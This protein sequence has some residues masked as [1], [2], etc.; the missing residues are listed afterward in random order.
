MPHPC[1]A[2]DDAMAKYKKADETL[3]RYQQHLQEAALAL[4]N[5]RGAFYLE[6]VRGSDGGVPTRLLG[7]CHHMDGSSFP[8]AIKIMNAL[9][10]WHFSAEQARDLWKRLTPEQRADRKSPPSE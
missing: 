8:D 9:G 4:K 2:Y 1:V 5:E 3:T 7:H 10:Q 6:S